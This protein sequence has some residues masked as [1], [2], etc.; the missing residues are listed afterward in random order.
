MD[1]SRTSLFHGK[2][3]M[4]RTEKERLYLA[5]KGFNTNSV[6]LLPLYHDIISNIHVC[7]FACMDVHLKW[8]C[9]HEIFLWKIIIYE[10]LNEDS[11]SKDTSRPYPRPFMCLAIRCCSFLWK[12][13][14]T[15]F[16]CKTL[17]K[18]IEYALVKFLVPFL[19]NNGRCPNFL[20]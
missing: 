10:N 3:A 11:Q 13:C 9:M 18:G 4:H 20:D 2:G 5:P 8:F 1:F 6:Q 12:L 19:V 16:W 14:K 17:G 15:L 7:C